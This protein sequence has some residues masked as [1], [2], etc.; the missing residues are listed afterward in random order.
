MQIKP[1]PLLSG[2]VR[3]FLVI[4]TDRNAVMRIFS[5]GNTGVVF[6]YGDPLS[7]ESTISQGNT[8][9]PASFLYGQL[10]TFRNVHASGKIR[11]LIAVLHPFGAAALFRVPASE[12]RNQI[13]GCDELYVRNAEPLADKVAVATTVSDKIRTVETFLISQ[14][15]DSTSG[16]KLV[17]N[18]ISFIHAENGLVPVSRLIALAGVTERQLQRKF[19]EYIGIS[20]KRYAGITRMQYALKMLRRKPGDLSLAGVAC[21]SGF[22]DQAHLIRE[23]KNLSGLTPGQYLSPQNLLAANLIQISR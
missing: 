19:E 20:P 6:N 18:T 7:Y 22:F 10:D 1:T 12:L 17:A 3:H 5:D 14:L 4:E 9:L 2:I 15:Q 21:E 16:G 8:R 23:M 13:I 11:L